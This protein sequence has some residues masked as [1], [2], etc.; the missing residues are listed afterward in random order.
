[1]V[2]S[3]LCE[4][5]LWPGHTHALWL[6]VRHS[7]EQVPCFTAPKELGLSGTP[8]LPPPGS[9]AL[10]LQNLLLLL[11]NTP[12]PFPL[13]FS[14]LAP[15]EPSIGPHLSPRLHTLTPHALLLPCFWTL[16]SLLPSKT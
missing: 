16:L 12:S 15:P 2:L 10:Y 9:P 7:Q 13:G 14:A 8:V 4:E 11:P 3:F 6:V 1:M 5:S